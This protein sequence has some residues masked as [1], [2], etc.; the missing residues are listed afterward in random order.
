MSREAIINNFSKGMNR[1]ASPLA[2]P[3]NQYSEAGNAVNASFKG[4]IFELS[5]EE[6]NIQFS[7]IQSQ[8]RPN[9]TYLVIGNEGIGEEIAVWSV[10]LTG[11]RSEIGVMSAGAYTTIL[12]SDCLDFDIRYQIQAETRLYFNNNRLTYWTE[13]L[14]PPRFLNLDDD[15]LTGAPN[16]RMEDVDGNVLDECVITSL[17]DNKT[18]PIVDFEGF[19]ETGGTL[20]VGVYHFVCRYLDN[21]LNPTGFG[22]ISQPVPVVDELREVGRNNY[23]GNVR[24]TNVAKA[25]KLEVSNIDVNFAFIDLI[26]IKYTGIGDTAQAF[27]SQRTG[28]TG[29]TM[30]FVFD[31]DTNFIEEITL[32]QVLIGQAFYKTAETISQKEGYLML[33]NLTTFSEGDLQNIANDLELK[34]RVKELDYDDTE[35]Q[36]VAT[37]SV[38]DIERVYFVEKNTDDELDLIFEFNK[39]V[40]LSTVDLDNFAIIRHFYD[41]PGPNTIV[42]TGAKPFSVARDPDNPSRVIATFTNAILDVLATELTPSVYLSDLNLADFADLNVSPAYSYGYGTALAGAAIDNAGIFGTAVDIENEVAGAG[43]GEFDT[44]LGSII[45]GNL[46]PGLQAPAGLSPDISVITN[47]VDLEDELNNDQYFGDYKDEEVCFDFKGYMREEIYSFGIQFVFTNGA[48]SSVYHIPG[49]NG[50]PNDAVPDSPGVHVDG[51]EGELGSYISTRKYSNEP[52]IWGALADTFV[53]HHK[54]PTQ[55]QEPVWRVPA[56]NDIKLRILS[57]KVDNLIAILDANPDVKAQLDRV[58]L[59]R[60]RR[61]SDQNR[62]IFMQGIGQRMYAQWNGSNPAGTADRN[63]DS[64]N[65]THNSAFFGKTLYNM[66]LRMRPRHFYGGDSDP[67][68][69]RDERYL[70]ELCQFYSPET[71]LLRRTAPASAKLKPISILKG[72]ARATVIDKLKATA[73][74]SGKAV[75]SAIHLYANYGYF[76]PEFNATLT[77]AQAAA[78]TIVEQLQYSYRSGFGGSTPP[79]NFNIPNIAPYE[80]EGFYSFAFQGGTDFQEYQGDARLIDDPISGV[81]RHDVSI[82]AEISIDGTAS[83]T[84]RDL[85]VNFA[86][87]GDEDVSLRYLYNVTGEN[88]AQYGDVTGA[89]HIPAGISPAIGSIGSSFIFFGGDIFISKISFKNSMSLRWEFGR[90]RNGD[91]FNATENATSARLEVLGTKEGDEFR[92]LADFFIESEVN[93]NYRHIEDNGAGV[94]HFPA[95]PVITEAAFDDVNND[96]VAVLLEGTGVLDADPSL[97]VSDAYN[98]LYSKENSVE[99]SVTRGLAFE[100]VDTFSDRVIFSEL[101][102]EGEQIDKYRSFLIDNFHDIPKYSGPITNL[103]VWDDAVWANTTDA[104]WRLYLSE[105]TFL[106]DGTGDQVTLGSSPLFSLP[107]KEMIT[108]DGGHAGSQSKFAGK[109]TPYGYIYPDMKRGK[110]F[111]LSEGLVEMSQDGMYNYISENLRVTPAT[112]AELAANPKFEDNP[113]NPAAS[114]IHAV[115]DQ[116]YKRYIF[117]KIDK[118][119]SRTE[120]LSYSFLNNSWIADHDYKPNIYMTDRE[121]FYSLLNNEYLT[122]GNNNVWLHNDNNS[123]ANFYGTQ[124]NFSLV[125]AFNKMPSLAK[126]YDNLFTIGEVYERATDNVIDREFFSSIQCYNERQ[127]S[128]VIPLVISTPE[129]RSDN[130]KLR[131]QQWQLAIPLDQV[132]DTEQNIFDISNLALN[133]PAN[134]PLKLFRPR[135]K[136]KFLIAKLIY[137]GQNKMTVRAIT[138]I[139]RPNAL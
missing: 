94:P 93:A 89:E 111:I 2:I 57:V 40:L 13:G 1:D 107:A 29:E 65:Y 119:N 115:Y 37:S 64:P 114:G 17:F 96:P 118:D 22:I 55:E 76:D 126:V 58:V 73:G 95:N 46:P 81:N 62:S 35:Q 129:L 108:T 23:N 86:K 19:D 137:T 10:D 133:L 36:E 78:P 71:T 106:T 70:D 128:D 131:N 7:T 44:L 61:N 132:L 75:G 117:T 14:N 24:G 127:N 109:A 101:S 100:E 38:L 26:A 69:L 105:K 63:D 16:Y 85:E 42:N 48:R 60:Q 56:L 68:A 47:I 87:D 11:T 33:S 139:V 122:A 84:T 32:E 52:S 90:R 45:T 20:E 77:A 67:Y 102:F 103:F 134:D 121:N 91:S 120:T 27:V 6:G 9:D 3:E 124:Y 125:L 80:C 51:S 82:R 66:G 99:V 88:L 28:I 25:I 83:T 104:L 97:G 138:A 21:N 123:Y 113:A 54:M 12:N 50:T 79:Q 98:D 59:T 110:I 39:P 30:S 92:A 130:V 31:N 135:M 136:G 15:R 8:A 116:R 34:Y 49:L 5:S 112:P 72:R 41:T 74:S 18:L 43:G 53:R 4:D